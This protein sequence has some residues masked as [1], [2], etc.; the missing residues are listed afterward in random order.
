MSTSIPG[1]STTF[2]CSAST[3]GDGD[4]I[5][6]IQWQL[7]NTPLVILGLDNVADVFLPQTSTG[8][9]TFSSISQDLNMTNVTCLANLTSGHVVISERTAILLVQGWLGA[10]DLTVPVYLYSN[11]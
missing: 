6:G 9:L 3:L 4:S 11:L 2:T 1:G 7:N 10:L 5:I 8:L